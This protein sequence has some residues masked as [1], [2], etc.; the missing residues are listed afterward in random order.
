LTEKRAFIDPNCQNLSISKQCELLD[1]HRSGY[2]YEPRPETTDNLLLMRMIDEQYLKTPFYGVR[3]MYAMIR[4]NGHHVNIKR[5]R[6]LIRLMDIEAIYPKPKT[7]IAD[8]AHK[9]Y[10][11]LLRGLDI[12]HKDQVW[13]ADITYIPMAT[14]FMYLVAI[15]DWFT[16]YVLAWQISNSLETSFCLEALEKALQ[17]AKPDIFNTDQGAQFTSSAFTNRIISSDIKMSMDGRRRALDNVFIER[18]W[19]SLKYEYVYISAPSSGQELWHGLEDY[20]GFYNNE[21]YHQSL[22]YRTPAN[23][24]I[25]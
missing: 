21:R 11:Y 7:S 20:F 12:T 4:A 22:D 25:N 10:P 14:G 6:R 18:L 2:Y 19:R 23:L 5:I 16:R 8:K 9:T 13:S 3:R 24:Y 1:I 17:T 15:I